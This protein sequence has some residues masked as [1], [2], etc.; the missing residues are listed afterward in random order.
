MLI[1]IRYNTEKDK[2]DSRLPAWRV[3]VNGEEQLA[4]SITIETRSWTSVD[5]IEPGRIKWHI[6]CEG[7][8]VWDAQKKTCTIKPE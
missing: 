6:S 4:E 1:K 8:V 3:L 2:T 5:E 7:R